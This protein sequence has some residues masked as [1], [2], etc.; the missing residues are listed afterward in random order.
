[1]GEWNRGKEK[2]GDIFDSKFTDPSTSFLEE[3]FQKRIN[4]F[5]A[6][7]KI[8]Q[9]IQS[10]NGSSCSHPCLPGLPVRVWIITCTLR[11][12]SVMQN[13]INHGI[14]FLSNR[15]C[16][17][18][19]SRTNHENLASNRGSASSSQLNISDLF[20]GQVHFLPFM[21]WKIG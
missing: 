19:K 11:F 12:L 15:Q 6:S 16:L 21:F 17:N 13:I 8:H 3:H 10:L 20:K 2:E 4:S 1:M 14:V 5:P 7:S 9:P 18:L